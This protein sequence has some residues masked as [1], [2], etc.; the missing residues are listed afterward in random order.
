MSSL[1]RRTRV[2]RY[3]IAMLVVAA[4]PVLAQ[5]GRVVGTVTDSTAGQPLEGVQ[6]L[7]VGSTLG[8]TTQADGRYTI[9]NVPPGTYTVETRRL[10]F[11][12][13]RRTGVVV[14]AGGSVT[15]D[16]R[17]GAAALQLQATVIT[18]VVDPTSGTRVPFT[19]G[20]VSA[21]NAPVPPTNSIATIQG[22]VAGASIISPAQPGSG[23][24]VVLRTPTSINQTTAPLFVVDGV[25]LG[26]TFDASTA[27]LNSLDIESVEVVK[28]AAAASLYGSRAANGVIQIRTRRGRSGD[29]GRTRFTARTEYGQNSL[30]RELEWAE[31]HFYQTN[32]QGQYVTAT[33]Q[34]TDRDGRVAR[35][36]SERFQDV[37]YI[38][39]IYDQVQE[40]FDPGTFNLNSFTLTQNGERTNF[41]GTFTN[42]LQSGVVL[43]NGGY[44]RNDFR[45]NLDHRPRDNMSFSVSGFHMRSRRDDLDDDT[46]FDLIHQAP[47]INL[48]EPDPD[49]TPYAFQPDPVGIRVNPLYT[50]AVQ[51]GK[52]N[53]ART[54]GSLDGRWSALS[55][56]TFDMNVSYDRSDRNFEEFTDKGKKTANSPQGGTGSLTMTNG[57]TSALNGSVSANLLG[58]VGDFTLRSTVRFLGEQERDE[59]FT[60]TGTD[61][62]V[63]GVPDLSAAQTRT[64]SST[65]E[66]I[67]SSGFFVTGGMDWRGRIIADALVRRDG[68][69]LFGPNERY[70]WY[71]R[72][73]LAW[74]MA[75]EPWWPVRAITEFK[76]RI[77]QGTAGNRPGFDYQ[78][79]T[80]EIVAGGGLQKENLGNEDLKPEYAT[81]TE[82]GLDV[83]FKNKYSLQLSYAN[84][85]IEDQLLQIPLPAASGYEAQWQ[86]AGT[87]EGNTFE[88][89]LEAQLIQR[90]DLT[91]RLGVVADRSRNEITEF[92]RSCYIRNTVQYVCEGEAITTMYGF[93]WV[94]STDQLPAVHAST[95]D[96]FQVNDDGLLVAVGPGGNYTDPGKWGTTVAIDG[97]N[98]G[99]GQPIAL[100]DATGANAV[101]KVGDGNPDFRWGISN[102]VRW[103]QFSFYALFESQV[104]GDVYNTTKQRMYQY[105]RHKDSDQA[106]KAQE[107]KK[108]VTYYNTTLYSATSVNDWFVEDGS[109]V[110]LRELSVQYRLPTRLLGPLSRGVS[111]VTFGLIGRNVFT[112]A[113][114]SGYD[115]EVG[116]PTNRLDNFIYPQF[117]TITGSLQIE[118]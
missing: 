80:Y 19:V 44:E 105:D 39:P 71:Y 116:S 99:W 78:Y 69:S 41:L 98:Y 96:Q 67:R 75:E 87:V 94:R 21:E 16:F 83:I 36:A 79:E 47:D 10:G 28:G 7:L 65:Y 23:I 37:T 11:Q 81:E 89:T 107:L 118:F 92:D 57:T 30:P 114:Y 90:P 101:V 45:L 77:S 48:L 73:S 58:A 1:V 61:F 24:N 91:W 15:V 29:Q 18:G 25:I 88:A 12:P 56:L 68:S 17:I 110:K 106:G 55:W 34:V 5:N 102:N 4:V 54:L 59:T 43:E 3:A 111:G 22:K 26:S 64:N 85:V 84:S 112:W 70:N 33:G 31:Q 42:Q 63:Q 76:P 86:N 40:F 117:R 109:Y 9:A 51:N 72:G 115:P 2:V 50:L 53:R 27:D 82:V 95:K 46:F 74:R 13:Q 49:G 113:G 20:R 108:A 93:S 32:A 66:D 35:P 60:A 103:K 38:D 97:I 100:R 8:A 62:V 14:A 104:G 52:T 6:V